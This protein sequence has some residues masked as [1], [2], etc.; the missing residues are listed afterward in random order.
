M[1]F[2]VV[3]MAEETTKDVEDELVDYE[4]DAEDAAEGEKTQEATEVKK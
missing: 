2:T 4:D 1:L 3:S